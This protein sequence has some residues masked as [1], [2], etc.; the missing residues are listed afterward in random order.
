MSVYQDPR[1]RCNIVRGTRCFCVLQL[2]DGTISRRDTTITLN[3]V[4]LTLMTDTWTWPWPI[5]T[6]TCNELDPLTTLALTPNDLVR[7]YIAAGWWQDQSPWHDD[8]LHVLRVLRHVQRVELSVAGNDWLHTW[9]KQL[10]VIGSRRLRLVVSPS[11]NWLRSNRPFVPL[12]LTVS[13]WKIRFLKSVFCRHYC[14]DAAKSEATV[15]NSI[16]VR[17]F[18]CHYYL[19]HLNMYTL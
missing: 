17:C 7:V 19:P 18:C 9:D 16:F 11:N 2:A 4:P 1:H 3:P 14:L 6:L 15:V 13:H 8:D 10:I 5:T 12:T